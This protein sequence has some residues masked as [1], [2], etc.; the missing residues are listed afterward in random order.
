MDGWAS[1]QRQHGADDTL[2][3]GPSSMYI[4]SSPDPGHYYLC[5]VG[6]KSITWWVMTYLARWPLRGDTEEEVP[7]AE[8]Y[9]PKV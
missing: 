5:T 7:Y 6:G 2:P 1:L 3:Q 4:Q 9:G 8:Q